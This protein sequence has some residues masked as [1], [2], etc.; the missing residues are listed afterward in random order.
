LVTVRR[1]GRRRLYRADQQAL[2]PLR[3]GLEA[4]WTAGL[5]RLDALVRE[6]AG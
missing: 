3:D 5:D 2:G 1:D 6:K 4:M